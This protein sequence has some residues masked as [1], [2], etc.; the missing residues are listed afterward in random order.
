MLVTVVS[1]LSGWSAKPRTLVYGTRQ[2]WLPKAPGEVAQ[3]YVRQ[4]I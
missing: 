1:L 3:L 2:K 4:L